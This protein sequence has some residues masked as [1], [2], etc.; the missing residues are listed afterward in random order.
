MDCTLGSTGSS[1]LAPI[2][3]CILLFFGS[4]YLFY[5]TKKRTRIISLKSFIFGIFFLSTLFSL[6]YGVNK[7]LAGSESCNQN[8]GK[9]ISSQNASFNLVDDNFNNSNGL[10]YGSIPFEYGTSVSEGWYGT[11]DVLSNDQAPSND[12]I[13][14]ASIKLVGDWPAFTSY[15][16]PVGSEY[17]ILNP[18]DPS[19]PT[20][21]NNPIDPINP[22]GSFRLECTD[23]NIFP[24]CTYSGKV[25][26]WIDASIPPNSVFN[27]KYT[28]KTMSGIVANNMATITVNA[29][30]TN[31]PPLPPQVTLVD[32]NYN[33]SSANSSLNV[34]SNDIAS[35]PNGNMDDNS[36]EICNPNDYP[37]VSNIYYNSYTTKSVIIQIDVGG[38]YYTVLAEVDNGKINLNTYQQIPNGTEFTFY[39][40]AKDQVGKASPNCAKVTM[41]FNNMQISNAVLV[42]DT[43][44]TNK[45]SFGMDVLANDQPPSGDSINQNSL[46]FINNNQ[47]SQIDSSAVQIGA[48]WYYANWYTFNGKAYVFID[49]NTPD[50][51]QFSTQYLANTTNGLIINSPATITIT[52][53]SGS[54]NVSVNSPVNAIAVNDCDGILYNSATV[55]LNHEITYGN[56]SLVGTFNPLS[57]D[58]DPDTPGRQTSYTNSNGATLSVDN[59]G[60]ITITNPR[61]GALAAFTVANTN[62]DVSNVGLIYGTWANNCGG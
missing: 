29:D 52:K 16:A 40:K 1:V 45:N 57:V 13:D 14:P 60:I 33:L 11:F 20:D 9:S 24:P 4:S 19:N 62:G 7:V 37:I 41:T 48:N 42:N 43:Y 12:P 26:V 17:W 46:I 2:I 39:Y 10:W 55:D 47:V 22:F 61:P 8:S 51:T 59:N 15:G 21:V 44:S 34:L 27:I 23:T 31:E 5:V 53:Q 49:K 28:A 38:Q 6:T 30:G 35:V 3:L 25:M 54:S 36:I 32:D 50:G 18:S 56:I 58:L